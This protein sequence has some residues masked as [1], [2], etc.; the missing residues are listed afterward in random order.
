VPA[1]IND[2]KAALKAGQMQRGLW[3]TLGS[4]VVAEIAGRAGFDWCLIDGEHAPFDPAA[5]RAQLIA[6]EGT[7]TAP[8]VRVPVNEDWLLK[9]VLDL[10]AQTVLVPMVDTAMQ[11]A[12]AVAAC[13]YPPLGRRGMGA[14]IAR[15]GYYG[16]MDGYPETANSQICVMVQAE[17]RAALENLDAICAVD[18][19]DAVFIGPADLACDM[20]Y[21]HDLGNMAV[22]DAIDAAIVTIRGH[23]MAAGIITFDADEQAR[24]AAAGVTVLGLGADGHTLSRSLR[25]LAGPA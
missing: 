5:I 25:A 9:Q 17:S 24:Y 20:G 6:L 19:V 16:A 15:A 21:T 10:G 7:G 11:A 2:F 22:R 13:R 8:I 14:A 12:A 4:G 3:L 23:D 1:P 18:G